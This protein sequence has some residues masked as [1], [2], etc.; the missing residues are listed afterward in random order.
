MYKF[1]LQHPHEVLP[2]EKGHF[3]LTANNGWE[4]GLIPGRE[5]SGRRK[6]LLGRWRKPLMTTVACRTA[7]FISHGFY[8]HGSL[9]LT[10]MKPIEKLTLEI[11]PFE[12]SYVHSILYFKSFPFHTSRYTCVCIIFTIQPWNTDGIADNYSDMG[13]SYSDMGLWRNLS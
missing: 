11:F 2:A 7:F 8:F 13:V 1:S 9:H 10:R 6:Q 3:F 4:T 12:N 5:N